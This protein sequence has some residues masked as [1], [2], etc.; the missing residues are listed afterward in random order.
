M[1]LVKISTKH[2][3]IST[4]YVQFVRLEVVEFGKIDPV[5]VKGHV[6]INNRAI[7]SRHENF[8]AAIGV[9]K[10][11]ISSWLHMN[12]VFYFGPPSIDVITVPWCA[13]IYNIVF[14]S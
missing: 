4:L 2:W 1:H 14:H 11:Q 5:A 12:W 6:W 8:L 10:H 13:D 3:G 7:T 9:E